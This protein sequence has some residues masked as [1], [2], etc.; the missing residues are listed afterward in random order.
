MLN[1]PN[2]NALAK[3]IRDDKAFACAPHIHAR[4]CAHVRA[5][6]HARTH[7]RTHADARAERGSRD[8]AWHVARYVADIKRRDRARYTECARATYN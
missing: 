5:Y 4:A 3:Q 7:A 2:A 8:K 1:A 6:T